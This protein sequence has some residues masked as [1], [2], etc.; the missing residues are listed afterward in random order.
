M[1]NGCCEFNRDFITTRLPRFQFLLEGASSLF[2]LHSVEVLLKYLAV[3]Y[4]FKINN[5]NPGKGVK[6]VQI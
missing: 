3:I 1:K 5:K 6:Y 2:P 4:L